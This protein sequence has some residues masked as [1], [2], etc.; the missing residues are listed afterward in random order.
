M[1]IS[2]MPE[3]GTIT[4]KQIIAL[5]GVA[6]SDRQSGNYRRKS[7]IKGGR[8]EMRTV[9]YITAVVDSRFNPVIS[10]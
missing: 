7:I 10:M 9:L 5:V 3:L 8:S 2:F 6:T 4:N 1:L